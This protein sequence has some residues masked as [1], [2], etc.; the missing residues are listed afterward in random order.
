MLVLLERE[1]WDFETVY[2]D[3]GCDWPETR[4]YVLQIAKRFP[5]TILTPEVEGCSNLYEYAWKHRMIPS[6]RVRWCT[7]NFKV[8]VINDYVARPC[9]MLIGFSTDEAHRARFDYNDGIERRFPLLEYELDR[10]DCVRI[11]KDAGLPVPMKS[12]CWFCPFQRK[13]QWRLL[14]QLHPDLFCKAQALEAREIAARAA[15]GK[16]PLR[17]S[18]VPLVHV[19]S[20]SQPALFSELQPPCLCE[21][22]PAGQLDLFAQGATT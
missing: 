4:D 15:R 2:V 20:E 5:I 21:R 6:R 19:V 9:Y 3:H 1:G 12:G 11:I 17:L 14:R 16:G 18:D 22:E 13:S 7:A 10:A 8:R